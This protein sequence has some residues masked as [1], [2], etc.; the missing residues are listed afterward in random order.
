M[1]ATALCHFRKLAVW[2]HHYAVSIPLSFPASWTLK[3]ISS[4]RSLWEVNQGCGLL[5]DHVANSKPW[6]RRKSTNSSIFV[7]PS[8]SGFPVC[9]FAYGSLFGI[10][11]FL[12]PVGLME[13][14]FRYSSRFAKS[15]EPYSSCHICNFPILCRFW[16]HFINLVCIA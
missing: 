15:S 4:R 11:S 6:K 7:L 1:K 16:F 2:N 3:S 8:F 5:W 12:R 10:V 14:L 13:I 9:C